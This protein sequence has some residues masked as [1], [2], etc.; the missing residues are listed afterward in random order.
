MTRSNKGVS[1]FLRLN[2]VTLLYISWNISLFVGR[3]VLSIGFPFIRAATTTIARSSDTQKREHGIFT[4]T[5]ET[6]EI[7]IKGLFVIA[8]RKAFINS[9]FLW[10][11]NSSMQP[12]YF[13]AKMLV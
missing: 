7:S 8:S 5:S 13:I 4:T 11:V 6:S 2:A 12:L 3:M 10:C 9:S 1:G